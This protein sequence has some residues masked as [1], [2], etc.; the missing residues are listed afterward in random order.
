M[1]YRGYLPTC[2]VMHLMLWMAS[3][4]SGHRLGKDFFVDVGA[5]IG[6]CTMHMASLGF[7]VISVEPVQQHV[8][9]DWLYIGSKKQY[10][11]FTYSECRLIR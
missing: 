5:N 8:S 4:V 1:M 10:N 9:T 3:E 6:S 2:R 7:P 11:V